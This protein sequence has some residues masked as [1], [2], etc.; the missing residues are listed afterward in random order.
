MCF[1][2]E[3]Q[4]HCLTKSIL[5]SLAFGSIQSR[6]IL[7]ISSQLKSYM[8]YCSFVFSCPDMHTD[9]DLH[10]PPFF[11]IHPSQQQPHL[12]HEVFSDMLT[13]HF[14]LTSPSLNSHSTFHL[15]HSAFSAHGSPHHFLTGLLRQPPHW[16]HPACTLAQCPAEMTF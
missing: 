5:P 7:Y 15:R 3:N 16:F 13:A 11:V 6:T 8:T 1:P 14:T 10:T 12:L 2:R 9:L 4:Q